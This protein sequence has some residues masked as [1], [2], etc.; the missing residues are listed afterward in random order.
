VN[1]SQV[2]V[3]LSPLA[4][5]LLHI[6]LISSNTAIMA[7]SSNNALGKRPVDVDDDADIDDLDGADFN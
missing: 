2:T 1:P 3:G 4:L 6:D 7:S 5:I